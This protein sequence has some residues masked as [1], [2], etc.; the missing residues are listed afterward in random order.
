MMI[1]CTSCK[2][3]F[4]NGEVIYSLDVGKRE[5]VNGTIIYSPL[6][7]FSAFYHRECHSKRQEW[8]IQMYGERIVSLVYFKGN[9]YDDRSLY[10]LSN[11]RELTF[12]V[13]DN[14]IRRKINGNL[15]GLLEMKPV[16]SPR[17]TITDLL[18]KFFKIKNPNHHKR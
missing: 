13:D 16:F 6:G 17:I 14:G 3:V 15:E 2:K 1:E 8:N 11:A 9:L 4:E 12:D 5:I 7:I 18:K 10:Q